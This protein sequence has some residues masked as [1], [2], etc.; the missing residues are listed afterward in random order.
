VCDSYSNPL[1]TRT[2][3][4]INTTRLAN[5]VEAFGE[6]MGMRAQMRLTAEDVKQC[7]NGIGIY[8]DFYV[9]K[10]TNQ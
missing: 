6:I 5:P 3:P 7:R 2:P 4:L 8:E 9:R 1:F 10:Q